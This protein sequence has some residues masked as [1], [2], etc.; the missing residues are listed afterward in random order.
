M[1]ARNSFMNGL[2]NSGDESLNRLLSGGGNV[3]QSFPL[4]SSN[5]SVLVPNIM[6]VEEIERMQQSVRN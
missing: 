5:N 1:P 2:L 4:S 3:N 6:S